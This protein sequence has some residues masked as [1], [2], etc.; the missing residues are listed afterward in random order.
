MNDQLVD[1]VERTATDTTPPTTYQIS[2]GRYP[3]EH[4]TITHWTED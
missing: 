2:V 3:F 4:L 1:A